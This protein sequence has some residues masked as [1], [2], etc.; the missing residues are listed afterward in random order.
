MHKSVKTKTKMF[1]KTNL[2]A[3][4]QNFEDYYYDYDYYVNVICSVFVAKLTYIIIH[5]KFHISCYN[6]FD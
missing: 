2:I 6:L 1:D 5:H 3:F 4:V